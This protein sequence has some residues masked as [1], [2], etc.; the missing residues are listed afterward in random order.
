MNIT[1]SN[2]IR[3]ILDNAGFT[4]TKSVE[5]TDIFIAVSCSVRERAEA[6][7]LNH[8]RDLKR[9]RG[10]NKPVLTVLTG[11]MV[12]R[13][14]KNSVC[15]N[16]QENVR[17]LKQKSGNSID[18][19]IDL[20][21]IKRLPQKLSKLGKGS[22]SPITINERTPS[23]YLQLQQKHTPDGIEAYIPIMTGCSQFCTYCIVPFSRGEE[24]CRTKKAII[25]DVETALSSGKKI[26]VLLGQ[27]VDKWSQDGKTFLDLL[28]SV[29]RID[30]EF[31]V[32]FLSPHPSFITNEIIDYIFK[33]PKM[34]KYLGLPLQAGS[35]RILKKMNRTYTTRKYLKLIDYIR[36]KEMNTGKLLYLTTDIIVGFPSETKNEFNETVEILN[37]IQFNKVFL[38]Y[39]SE[40]PFSIAAKVFPD[41]IPLAEKKKRK[42]ILIEVT[43]KIFESKNKAL[44]GKEVTVIAKTQ[45]IGFMD[46][47]QFVEILNLPPNSIGKVL[48]GKITYGGRYG[49]RVKVF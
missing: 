8:I 11:C 44:L 31:F 40:R 36:S 1:D 9:S 27:I 20:R 38:A 28:K 5:D 29:C 26:I 3:T 33:E 7:T 6:K 35:N 24:F 16:T 2:R 22:D 4:E 46:T 42:Q 14:H 15:K 18:I 19:Y 47:Y 17:N 41:D 25:A 32:T 37:Q 12:R 13:D 39:Y 49:I 23:S 43:D 45:K 21:D 48:K 10:K 34:L 30:G